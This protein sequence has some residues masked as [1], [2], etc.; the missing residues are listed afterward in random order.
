[1]ADKYALMASGSSVGDGYGPM[2]VATHPMSIGQIKGKKIAIPGKLTTAYL[3]LKIMQPDFEALVTPFDKILEAVQ[4]G[5]ADIGLIIH[6]A[7]LTYNK[8]GFHKII[9]LGKWWKT[10]YDL[11]R[12][13]WGVTCCY[14]VCAAG[15]QRECSRMMRD[16]I[17]YARQPR[18][19]ALAYA[20][21]F[22]QVIWIR[23]WPRNS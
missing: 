20:M 17:Q 9:D 11:C 8:S 18:A 1:M 5:A 19:E 13:L 22:A 21:H 15:I 3:T 12:C 16:S 4:E 2:L 14:G 23:A 10:T 6:E 7:Q